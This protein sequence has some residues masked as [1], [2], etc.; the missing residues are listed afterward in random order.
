MARKTAVKKESVFD[1]LNGGF[2]ILDME[3]R[4]EMLE[5][6]PEIAKEFLSHST[7][8]RPLKVDRIQ[9][10]TRSMDN[11]E[12]D[13]GV[14][15]I[16]FD[17]N[18]RLVNGHH[19]CQS[20]VLSDKPQ[21]CTIQYNLPETAVEHYDQKS[22]VRSI[23][24]SLSFLSDGRQCPNAKQMACVITKIMTWGHGR[25]KSSDNER[26]H[27]L[28]DNLADMQ[29]TLYRYSKYCNASDIRRLAP[30]DFYAAGYYIVK[31]AGEKAWHE[32]V[33]TL[34]D[35][36]DTRNFSPTKKLMALISRGTGHK[37]IRSDIFA[38]TINAFNAYAK[39]E[40]V[41]RLRTDFDPSNPVPYI[42]TDVKRG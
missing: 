17:R 4:C 42:E 24:D 3:P 41:K 32:F 5:V 13:T 28:Y 23:E 40:I 36:K 30:F 35:M 38:G 22:S 39:G 18:K 14:A 29:A 34:L 2:G 15:V 16:S 19:V 26:V 7:Y 1:F 10:H 9:T 11:G 27:F 6:T 37:S 25:R 21:V 12:W 31:A 8:N 20:I 33:D